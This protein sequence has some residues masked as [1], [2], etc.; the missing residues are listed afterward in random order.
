MAAALFVLGLTAVVIAVWGLA[1]PWWA[2]LTLGVVLVALAVLTE[3]APADEPADT[4]G[5]GEAR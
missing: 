5:E 4:A 2:L 3:R 1:G